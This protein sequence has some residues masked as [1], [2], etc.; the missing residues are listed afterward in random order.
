MLVSVLNKYS[1]EPYFSPNCGHQGVFNKYKVLI[2]RTSI[3][4][5]RKQALRI[6]NYCGCLIVFQIQ[7]PQKKAVAEQEDE[8]SEELKAL[9]CIALKQQEKM[10]ALNENREGRKPREWG[11]FLSNY[12]SKIRPEY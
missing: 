4:S 10:G 5:T 8:P 1:K 2:Y 6:Q 3:V 7:K 12:A 9:T 11:H